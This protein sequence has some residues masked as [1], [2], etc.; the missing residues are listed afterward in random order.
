MIWLAVFHTGCF[1][2]FSVSDVISYI[3]LCDLVL[4]PLMETDNI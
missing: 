4:V 3:L 2:L 1:C